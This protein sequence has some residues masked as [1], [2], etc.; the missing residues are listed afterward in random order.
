MYENIID[1]LRRGAAEEALTLARAAATEHPEDAQAHRLLAAAQ[2]MGGDEEAAMSSIDRAIALAPEDANLHLDRA[3][4]L[5]RGRKL[6]EASEALARSSGLD[7]NL[8]P[9]YVLQAQLAVA[10]GDLA[11]AE[12]LTRTAARIDPED[13]QVIA[14]EGTLA[15]RR[16]DAD[17]AVA[18]LAPSTERH[19]DQPALRL[20]LGHA[21][22]AK[23]HLA[24][25]EQAFRALRDGPHD[26]LALR[27]MLADLLRRQGR[28]EEAARELVPMLSTPEAT[29]ALHRMVGELELLAGRN[30]Q[31]REHLLEALHAQPQDWP[32]VS[33]T[34][35]A[36]RRLGAAEEA[37]RTLDA[38]L[39]AHPQHVH[40]WNARLMVEPFAGDAARAVVERWREADP[41]SVPALES[42]MTIHASA[43]EA[44]A[45]EAVAR[46]IVELRPGHTAARDRIIDALLQRDA[47]AAIEHVRS[48]VDAAGDLQQKREMRRIL[49]RTMDQAG[50]YS[51]AADTWVALNAELVP[52]R[53][54][55]PRPRGVD[56]NLLPP[57]IPPEPT[58]QR[59]LLLWG[60]PGS[61]VE[62]LAT[63][64]NL[65]GAQLLA[66]RYGPRPPEDFLQQPA[67]IEALADRA[68]DPGVMAAQW[69]RLLPGRVAR[70]DRPAVDWLLWWDNV[71]LSV[72]RGHMPEALL[73]IA[74]RDPRDM[75]MDWLAAGAPAPLALESPE[76]AAKWLAMVL[77]QV[78]DI[79]EHD[80]FPLALLRVDGI[81]DDPRALASAL[82][83]ALRSPVAPARPGTFGPRRLAP[84]HWRE[85]AGL[86]GPAFAELAD[87]AVRLGYP[88]E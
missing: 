75:L 19:P 52:D 37:R 43:G 31:A 67:A 1:A 38:L 71:L 86:L 25:A 85:Y 59:V 51:D 28:P 45:A 22:A 72:V 29:P 56:A 70:R 36:W 66:D 60:A 9:S 8:L 6:G 61:M 2:R 3:A 83:Q 79:N 21:Y 87:V 74:V 32:T 78:A 10:R 73:M 40:L 13:P 80:L 68:A 7:P 50:R 4:L 64:L 44:E 82:S 14:L 57:L 88:R 27:L 42:A 65:S 34:C 35:E 41:D 20:A 49:G 17:R 33:A 53:I 84:G 16:G 62:R 5:L 55:L 54:A 26:S 77:D 30:E 46:R 76:A 58:S 69:R 15:L 11:E 63:T 39:E 47:D 12:R 81:E 48:M 23:G 18:I 24:F